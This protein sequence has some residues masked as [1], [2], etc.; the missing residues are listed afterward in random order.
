MSPRRHHRRAD[1]APALD[2]VR[3]RR[4][5]DAVQTW[6]DGGW[7]VRTVPGGAATKA[8]RC[9]GCDQE[10]PAGVA[11]VVVW[12]TEDTGLAG[13]DERRHWHT[14]CWRARGRRTPNVQRGRSAPRYG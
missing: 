8:Y 13:V 9:P 2:E 10:I 7:T 11:H 6:A 12:P 14:G 3:V 1:G 5:A 4:G